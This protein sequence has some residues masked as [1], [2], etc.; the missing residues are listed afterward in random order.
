MSCVSIPRSG[1]LVLRQ[2]SQ[3]ACRVALYSFNPSFGFSGSETVGLLI[4]SDEDIHVSI[5]RSGFLVLRLSSRYTQRDLLPVS[6][7]R[8]GFLVLRPSVGQYCALSTPSFNPSFGF[9]G[10]E[11]HTH[12]LSS[13]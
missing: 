5:P 1:F 11:T 7:P 6:I 8:S 9:S 3:W 12:G 10:S 13:G 2:R 4:R